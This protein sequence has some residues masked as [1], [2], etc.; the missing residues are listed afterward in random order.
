MKADSFPAVARA[1]PEAR[2]AAADCGLPEEVSGFA[3]ARR[4]RGSETGRAELRAGQLGSTG[5]PPVPVGDSP[6]G[7]AGR[8]M[9]AVAR[10]P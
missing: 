3:G 2:P 5:D 7:M 4:R 8:S 6:N 9:T 1:L 10:F